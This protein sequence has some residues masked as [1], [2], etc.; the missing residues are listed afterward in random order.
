MSHHAEVRKQQR[1]ITA[2]IMSLHERYADQECFVGNGC[3]SRTLS[4]AAA[5]KMKVVGIK[6]QEIEK[7]RK[8]AIV[9]ARTDE[10]VTPLFVFPGQG[11]T[12]R[13]GSRKRYSKRNNRR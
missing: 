10:V 6:Q 2:Q 1:G 3:I 7:V 9:Y 8:T 12:Y 5:K 13:R 4:N 11:H